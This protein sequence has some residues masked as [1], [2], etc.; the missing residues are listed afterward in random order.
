MKY[1]CLDCD[2]FFEEPRKCRETH[3]LDTPPYEY[4]YVCPYCEGSFIEAIRCD[5]CREYIIGKYIELD[6]GI[7]I[8]EDCYVERSVK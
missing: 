2:R 1:L 7:R 4:F 6:N 5:I 3:G 8:C